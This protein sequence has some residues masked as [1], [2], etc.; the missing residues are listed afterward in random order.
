MATERLA[1]AARTY[2]LACTLQPG[3]LNAGTRCE[4]V[5]IIANSIEETIEL[6][7]FYQGSLP[8]AALS[9]VTLTDITGAVI[10]AEQRD[11]PDVKL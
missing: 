2:R 8:S 5:S 4:T 1:M 10:W 3:G 7:R 9:D 11:E 6:A